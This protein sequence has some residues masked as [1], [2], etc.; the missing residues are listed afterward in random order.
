MRR[1]FSP[2]V[3]KVGQR[4]GTLEA[5]PIGLLPNLNNLPNL[6]AHVRACA[7]GRAQAGARTHARVCNSFYVRKVRKVR[8]NQAGRA[9]QPSQPLPNL[10]EVRNP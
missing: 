9:F 10:T 2:E 5:A 7:G 3:R 4:L 8:K 6:F 1:L